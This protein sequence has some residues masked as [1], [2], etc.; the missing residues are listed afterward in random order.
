[1]DEAI[2]IRNAKRGNVDAFNHLVLIY[3]DQ[4]FN[5]AYR[6]LNDEMAAQDIAQNTFINAFKHLKSFRRGSFRAWILRI[7]ANNCYDELRRK[8]R[9]PAHP[10]TV[11]DSESGEEMDDP[12]WLKDNRDLPEEHII[13]KELEQA[14]QNCM[15]QLPNNYRTVIILVDIQ[16]L[17]Y[18][19]ASQITRSPVG[20]IRS[21]L[22][23]A[24]MRIQE[25]LQGFRELLPRKYRFYPGSKL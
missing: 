12:V 9:K 2:L 13:K 7:A 10:L 17:A 18:Q 6:M 16:G 11:I 23:R 15:D 8:K 3:Q 25:C 1:M 20:T 24:R 5:L 4:V 14:I 22:A 19:E 21:R